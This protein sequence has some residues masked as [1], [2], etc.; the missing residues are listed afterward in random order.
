MKIVSMTAYGN[1]PAYP[2][3]QEINL[4]RPPEGYAEFPE[5]FLPVFKPKGKR[6]AGFVDLTFETVSFGDYEYERVKNCVWDEEAYRR[7]AN[8]HPE[9]QPPSAQPSS[10][11]RLR[12]DVD[13]LLMLEEG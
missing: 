11:E 1:I 13:F 12:A 9:E 8:S 3:I 6:F 5:E 2:P 10:M 4:E 7:Y